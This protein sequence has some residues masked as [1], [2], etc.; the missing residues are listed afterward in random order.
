MRKSY[1]IIFALVVLLFTAMG[2]DALESKAI[3]R[4]NGAY[5]FADWAETNGDVT[6]CTYLS[7]TETDDGTDIYVSMWEYNGMTGESYD[8]YGYMFT[9]DDIFSIDKKLDSASLSA[10][11]IGVEK[12]FL[13]YNTGEYV[14]ETGTVTVEADWTGIGDI[15]RGSSRYVS[16]DGDYVFRSTDNSLSRE[17]TV[18]GLIDG[19]DP[20]TQSF[21]SMSRFKTAYMSMEK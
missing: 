3:E 12:W 13:D 2:V 1:T 17:A 6:T 20:G 9:E 15:S 4:N 8:A 10:V 11:D 5:A 14:Y 21:A 18:T 16:R 19:N 7:V